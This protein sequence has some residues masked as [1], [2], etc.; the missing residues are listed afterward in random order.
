M[1]RVGKIAVFAFWGWVVLNLTI[2]AI[3]LVDGSLHKSMLEA[4]DYAAASGAETGMDRN[5]AA[6][7]FVYISAAYFVVT[8]SLGAVLVHNSALGRGWALLVLS[9]AAL[10]WAYDS[11]SSPSQ[12]NQMY[13]G[14]MGWFDW[15]LGVLGGIV[16][17]VILVCAVRVRRGVAL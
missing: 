9:P 17:V 15:V 11:V 14:T 12:L 5:S 3:S 13:P 2:W 16:W 1:S 6:W 8:T 7:S 4:V 10:W